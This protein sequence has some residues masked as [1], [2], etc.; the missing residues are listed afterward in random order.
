[1]TNFK[2]S[3]LSLTHLAH[4]RFGSW[5]SP[6]HGSEFEQ[7]NVHRRQ[8]L[9]LRVAVRHL[10]PLFQRDRCT[11]DSTDVVALAQVARGGPGSRK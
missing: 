4:F 7:V 5:L 6:V 11:S 9:L 1:M 8:I 2:P 3:A 10:R